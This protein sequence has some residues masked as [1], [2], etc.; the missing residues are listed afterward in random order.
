MDRFEVDVIATMVGKGARKI[1]A[2]SREID[3]VRKIMTHTPWE[4]RERLYKK[5]K[6][7]REELDVIRGVAG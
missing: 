3:E 7:L 2:R 1:E 6:E 4:K 5:L